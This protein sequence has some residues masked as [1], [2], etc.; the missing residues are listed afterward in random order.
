MLLPLSHLVNA[1]FHS[2]INLWLAARSTSTIGVSQK[3]L[4]NHGAQLKLIQ[5]AIKLK[6][7]GLT[8]KTYA[9]QILPYP[10]P[11]NWPQ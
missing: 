9:L 6:V 1:C 10:S 7:N 8:A 11:S 3:T 2:N 5:Q 4:K